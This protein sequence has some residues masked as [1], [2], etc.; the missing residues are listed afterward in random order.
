MRVDE[1]K[2]RLQ[3]SGLHSPARI[4]MR[5]NRAQV[6]ASLG[7]WRLPLQGVLLMQSETWVKAEIGRSDGIIRHIRALLDEQ[8]AITSQAQE[9]LEKW[10]TRERERLHTL[11]DVMGDDAA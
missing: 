6:W 4:G 1:A 5:R 7:E 2:H 9:S 3:A 10:L 8:G 11:K